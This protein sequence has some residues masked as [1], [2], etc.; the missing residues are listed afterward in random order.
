MVFLKD[1]ASGNIKTLPAKDLP[2]INEK[3]QAVGV[4]YMARSPHCSMDISVFSEYFINLKYLK[5]CKLRFVLQATINLMIGY[6]PPASI[7]P[8]SNDQPGVDLSHGDPGTLWSG[9]LL[10]YSL[11]GCADDCLLT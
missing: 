7:T 8:I 5:T 10:S 9:L 3:Q 6:E 4:S 11:L 2:L 1:L